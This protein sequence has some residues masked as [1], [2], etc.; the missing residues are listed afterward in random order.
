MGQGTFH[1]SLN[2]TTPGLQYDQVDVTNFLGSL[3]A[4]LDVS[5]GYNAQQ[6]DQLTIINYERGSILTNGNFAGLPEGSTFSADGDQ[7]QITYKGGDGNDVVLTVLSTPEPSAITFATACI[8]GLL[9]RR[10][11]RGVA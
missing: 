8:A 6:G 7:F 10:R 9:L 1:V 11:A 2:G 3:G 4:N 5:V